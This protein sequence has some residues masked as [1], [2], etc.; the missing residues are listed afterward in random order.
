MIDRLSEHDDGIVIVA[1]LNYSVT[2]HSP[3]SGFIFY[4]HTINY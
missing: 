3:L 2:W 4:N 1:P